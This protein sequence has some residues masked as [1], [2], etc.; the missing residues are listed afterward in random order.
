VKTYR[1]RWHRVRFNADLDNWTQNTFW[2]VADNEEAAISALLQ[3]YTERDGDT[4]DLYLDSIE[5]VL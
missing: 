1:L 5:V 4:E 3:H 2:A